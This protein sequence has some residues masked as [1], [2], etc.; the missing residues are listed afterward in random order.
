M[1]V[2]FILTEGKKKSKTYE[3]D[4]DEYGDGKSASTMVEEILADPEF[5]GLKELVIGDWGSAWDC[6]ACGSLFS[7]RTFVYRRYGL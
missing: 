6:G 4:Y 1:S 2:N 5:A 7:Y 3:Y